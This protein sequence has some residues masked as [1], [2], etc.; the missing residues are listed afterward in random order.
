MDRLEKLLFG[1][2]RTARI[3]EVGPS[4]NPVAPKAAGWRSFVLDH[5]T[6]DDLK[7]KYRAHDVQHDRIEPVDFVW[8]GGPID[9]AV[10][11]GEHGTFDACIASHVLEHVPD[12]I[13]FFR[14]LDRLLTANG[15]V[16]LALPDKRFCFDYFR[17]LTLAPAWIEAYERKSARHSRRT[18]LE[19]A[20]YSMSNA[21]RYAWGQMDKMQVRLRGELE[22]AKT[23]ADAAGLSDSDPYVDCHAW[24]FTP[25]SFELLLLELGA[26]GMIEFRIAKLFPTDGCEFI[27]SLRKGRDKYGAAV[28][29][30]RLELLKVM[31]DEL[32]DQHRRMNKRFK[33]RAVYRGIRKLG[34]IVKAAARTVV[35][36]K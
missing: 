36:S 31:V 10:P 1:I 30:R 11:A 35:P 29:P 3:L 14:S 32:G 21:D 28:Q 34:R 20:A 23:N 22:L 7:E 15:V 12:P 24:C 5:A 9:G 6:Q 4:H 17:Q 8:T 16:S 26:L 27:V 33:P 13:G 2:E 25:S 19:S 18:V